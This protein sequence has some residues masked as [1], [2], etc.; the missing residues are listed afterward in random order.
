[1]QI[2]LV[3][4]KGVTENL[5]LHTLQY[6]TIEA[7]NGLLSQRSCDASINPFILITFMVQEIF[8]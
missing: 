7:V 6:L 1:M 2:L 8:E 3:A 5:R 4:E